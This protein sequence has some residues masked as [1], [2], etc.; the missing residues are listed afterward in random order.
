MR[1][2]SPKRAKQERQYLRDREVFLSERPRCEMRLTDCTVWA[3]EVHHMR[4]R[5]GER[6]L[7]QDYWLPGCRPC[8]SYVTVNPTEAYELG[9]SVHRNAVT[10]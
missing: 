10:T 7:D 4:G 1:A 8:H 9:L 2:R 6:L 3:T 5:E